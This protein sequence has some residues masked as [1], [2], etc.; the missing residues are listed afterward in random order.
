MLLLPWPG[1][2]LRRRDPKGKEEMRSL[3]TR[4]AA[5]SAAGVTALAHSLSCWVRGRWLISPAA[6]AWRSTLRGRGWPKQ[7]VMMGL[8]F[9]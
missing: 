7:S 6:Q 8:P 2:T 4:M 9:C 3:A 1:L 5:A